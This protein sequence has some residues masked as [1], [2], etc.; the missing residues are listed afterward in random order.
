MKKVI[1]IFVAIAIVAGL[2][3]LF[4]R[5]AASTPEAEP[6]GAADGGLVINEVMTNN[7][8][9]V[10]DDAGNSSDCVELYNAT[11]Q[12]I[13]LGRY[14]LSD[15]EAEP[16]KWGFPHMEIAPHSYVVV[17]LT[18]DAQSNVSKGI[19]HCSF[20]LSAQGETLVLADSGGNKIDSVAIPA[21]PEN[22][23]YGL[24]DG[25]MQQLA[26]VTPGYENS[27]AGYAAF[28]ASRTV[29][30][31]AV[32]ITEVMA[33][34]A[35][36]LSDPQGSYS[37]WIE[38]ANVG[39]KDFDLSGCG[40]SDD[41]ADLLKW[42]FPDVTLGAGESLV[43][44]CS[45]S[46]SAYSGEGP[47]EA[48][49]RLSGHGMVA[50][51]SD[52][53]GRMMDSASAEEV[54]TDWSYA[55]EYQSG[56][57]S[58]AWKLT[59]QP[60]PGYPN[61][62]DGFAAFAQA[63]PFATGDVIISEVLCS[64]NRIDFGGSKSDYIEIEN[65]G[66][67]AVNLSGFGLTDN[68]GNPAKF[69]FPDIT[70]QPGGRIVVLAVGDGVAIADNLCAAFKLSRLGTTLAL[71]NAQD[72]L[73]DRY[74]IG[75][76][77]QN[78]SV[79][80]EAGSAA[81][82]Y[83]ETPTPGAANGDG[84]AGIA[85]A[86]QFGQSAGKY[87]GAVQLMLTAS[88]GCDIY[89][90]TDGTLPVE[91]GQ[92]GG[93]AR[94]YTGPFAVSATTPVR[95]SA[96][97]ADYIPST[98]ATATYFI[99]ATH[100][101]PVV[102]ITTDPDNLFNEQTGI[103]MLGP[104]PGSAEAYYP[105]ANYR[106]DTE[107]PASFEVYDESGQRVFQQDIGLA[108][109][110]GLSLSLREQKSFAIYARSQYG[111]STMSYPFFENRPFTEY[112]SLILRSGGRDTSKTKLNTFVALG[113]VDGQMDVMTQAA[114]P[115]VLYIDG[116]YWGVYFMMEK[117]NKYMVAAHEGV[118]DPAAIDTINLTKGLQ[119][120]L[121]SSGSYEGYAEIFNYVKTH[122]LSIQENYDWVDARL[123]TDSYMDL[124]INEIYI[125]NND[126]GNMQY[127]QVPPGGLWT[128]IYQDLDNAFYSFDTLA[129]RM[130]P[131]TAGSDIF[132]ALL[133][134][135]G[136]RNRFIERFAWALK[137]IYSPDRVIAMIDAGADAMRGEVA[138]EHAR[139]SELPTLE[140]WEA[141]V[142]SMKNFAKKR[143]AA[144]VGYLKQ[145]FTW[146][147]QAQINMLEEAAGI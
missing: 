43:I 90:T 93:T 7:Q 147:S 144:M 58:G 1:S 74:F 37:D 4:Q 67:Q 68:A 18:G 138:A 101:L 75:E 25:T 128:Q 80:R 98:A 104:N 62:A 103:Y 131:S 139:W 96:L 112:K 84:K 77:P 60:T 79:G 48:D 69:R 27:D 78:I 94:K 140:E 50:V 17:Y 21:L 105:T 92:P 45:G 107:V 54:P 106:S 38:I 143:P 28:L 71:F 88:E 118:T 41:M 117:R 123:D 89:Y 145:H 133:K 32:V 126:P 125:A 46:V 82:A 8:G 42:R 83:F 5:M 63:N 33:S 26:H 66:A 36:T 72:Q 3:F 85:S 39:G 91:N 11:D 122:D 127:Y 135:E 29:E 132:N 64:N 114:K 13:N 51:L 40:L 49:F 23:S 53:A 124:M 15:D 130:N 115:C 30:N 10:P 120:R 20:K 24:F 100:T 56:A 129:L 47:L 111:K 87:P 86:V 102:S 31:P 22:V 119:D 116:Q 6:S 55:R 73:I 19:L 121:V 97:R 109:T 35:M 9:I 34:N 65:R 59:S 44:F 110:G 95:A 141:G 57:P 76:V 136:W 137:N 12:P 61:T 2:V 108:M 14:G 52:A 142:A 113:L 134:N 99:A 81:V 146:L 16:V 70:L